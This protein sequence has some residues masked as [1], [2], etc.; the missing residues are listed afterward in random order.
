[1]FWFFLFFYLGDTKCPYCHQHSFCNIYKTFIIID[2][3]DLSNILAK[4][5]QITSTSLTDV[6]LQ[7]MKNIHTLCSLCLTEELGALQQVQLE[8]ECLQYSCRRD[9]ILTAA[10]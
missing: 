9:Y 2:L 8:P 4:E 1:M 7:Q 10:S 3:M 5:K 6:F